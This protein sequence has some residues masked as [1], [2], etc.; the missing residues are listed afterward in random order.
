MPS[1]FETDPAAID[2][3]NVPCPF[4][5]RTFVV[6]FTTLYDSG[7]FERRSGALRSAP[8]STTAIVI[9]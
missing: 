2:D 6:P 4:R 3:T 7:A 8:V 5:S 9:A 1:P